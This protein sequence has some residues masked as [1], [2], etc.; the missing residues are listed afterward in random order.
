[1]AGAECGLVDH[2]KPFDFSLVWFGKPLE[3][4]ERGLTGPDFCSIK[5]SLAAAF[6]RRGK[7]KRITLR[8]WL[9]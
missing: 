9:P 6:R 5:M 7:R 2:W 8:G 4:F 1:M 3:N